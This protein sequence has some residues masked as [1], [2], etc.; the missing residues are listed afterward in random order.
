MK[1]FACISSQF[2][3]IS[4]RTTFEMDGCICK[5]SQIKYGAFMYWITLA[6]VNLAASPSYS[7]SFLELIQSMAKL[8]DGKEYGSTLGH[9]ERAA[10][11]KSGLNEVQSCRN[12]SCLYCT[13]D[14]RKEL[15][16]LLE[17]AYYSVEG[18][19]LKCF[20]GDGKTRLAPCAFEEHWY[21]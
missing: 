20:K 16:K 15:K 14:I 9:Y 19:C 11:V 10:M 4:R 13:R 3:E 8:T 17:D 12:S 21:V 5:S 7:K 2:D 6:G 18:Y 1:V